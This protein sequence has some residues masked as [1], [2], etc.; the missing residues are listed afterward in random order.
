MIDQQ[1]KRGEKRVPPIK[2]IILFPGRTG[3]TYLASH[4]MSHPQVT[5]RYELLSRCRESWEQQL[6]CLNDLYQQKRFPV[7]KAVGFKSK[8]S[9]VVDRRAFR[10]YLT[11]NSIKVIYQIRRNK[12]KYIVSIIRARMLR[13]EHGCSNVLNSDQQPI[14]PIEIPVDVFTRA[15]RRFNVI[16]RLERFVDKLSLPKLVTAYEDLLDDESQELNRIWDFLE[17]DR[18]PT[19]GSTRKNTPNDI[20]QAVTNIDEIIQRHPEMAEFVDA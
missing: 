7:V 19:E 1:Q 20:R 15:T 2:Y 4:M 18:Q 17:V 8:L 13:A 11:D 14:G 16:A 6:D 5:A 12:L 3:S 10:S 9:Q